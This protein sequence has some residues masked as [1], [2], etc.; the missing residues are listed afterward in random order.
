MLLSFDIII[1]NNPW[2]FHSQVDSDEDLAELEAQLYS[3]I[4]YESSEQLENSTNNPEFNVSDYV[5]SDTGTKGS[6]EEEQSYNPSKERDREEND[7]SHINIGNQSPSEDSE[8]EEES[9]YSS[10]KVLEPNPF[11]SE[12]ESSEDEGIID[13]TN[14]KD[15]S[16][17]CEP[18]EDSSSHPPAFS[19]DTIATSSSESEN[20][21]DDDDEGIIV[22]PAPPRDSP[23]VIDVDEE[24]RESESRIIV[25]QVVEVRARSKSKESPKKK[26]SVL[27]INQILSKGKGKEKYKED[28]GS[29]F[30][31]N[32]LSD[33]DEDEEVDESGISLG[34]L[35]GSKDKTRTG[36]KRKVSEL[37]AA[38]LDEVKTKSI[39]KPEVWTSGMEK[40][41]NKVDEQLMDIDL[42]KV[43]SKMSQDPKDWPVDRFLN[44]LLLPHF[45][46]LVQKLGA[47]YMVGG[48]S[49]PDILEEAR[50]VTTATSL[51]IRWLL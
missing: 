39:E 34:N 19:N 51:D 43:L 31:E 18:P 24:S 7:N 47:M 1:N 11:Y 5:V 22:L 21:D 26:N 38:E 35:M 45:S 25:E 30:E 3:Q 9:R 23:V 10:L 33:E 27:K 29:D 44:I 40:F 42:D 4:Y 17:D 16:M 41:Y 32:F 50:D 12:P 6:A 13:S 20:D 28:Y 15:V 37:F 8:C 46:W 2:Q 36:G 49:V 48:G 14:L